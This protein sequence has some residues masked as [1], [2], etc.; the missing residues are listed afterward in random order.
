[1]AWSGGGG[2]F[3][4]APGGAGFAGGPRS[5]AN[6]GG[7][8]PFAGIPPELQAGVDKLLTS[9]PDHGEPRARFS[10]RASAREGRRLT[11]R[12]LLF[13]HW[14]LGALAVL[15]VTV[16]SVAN[17]A[18][19]RLIDAGINHGMG[20]HKD[21]G[22]IV[23]AAVAY[24]IAIVVTAGAQHLQVRV[25]GR[26]AAWVMN[27]LRVKV[28][29]HLQRLG[30]DF[31]TDEK[32]GVIMTRMTSDIEN[33][34][35][36]LQDG[37][38]QFTVQGLTMLVIA[39][40]L[41][42]MN[43][44]LALITVVLIMPALTALSLWFRAASE[45]GY[46]RV[47]DGIA[48]VLA[49]LAESL[50]G[51][52]IVAAHNRQRH[53][54][55]HHRNV[56]G[57]YRDANMYTAQINAV[58]GP[59]TQML[60]YLGSGAILAIGGNMVLHHTLSP[61]DL[62]AFFLYLNR[63]LMPIQLLVQ[64]Y[65]TYQQGQASIIKLRTLF[66][67]APSVPEDPDAEELPP[68]HG[69]IVFEDVTF[70]YDPTNPVI[71]HADLRISAGETVA[72]VGPTGAGKSTLAK[73]VTR[74]YDPGQG[75]VL[76]DGHDLRHVTVGSLRR[77]LGVVPQEPFLFAGTIRDNIA[78]ADPEATDDQVWEAIR[79]VGLVDVVERM[80]AGLDTIVHE[81]G[82]SL[83]SGERQLI[84]L[85]RAFMAR[86][87][88]LVLDEAT[89]NLDL[90]SETKIEAALDVLLE[91]RTAVLIAHRLTTAMKA[92]RIVVV[93]EGQVV[94]IGTH[95]ELV[96]R[97]GRYAAMYATWMSHSDAD[98]ERAH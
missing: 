16:V 74:F 22:A 92:D 88:V 27:D 60:G 5:A 95:D 45:R 90:L 86:P 50:H 96:A 2:V 71:R 83:S 69:E 67:V 20:R 65:N 4:G 51:V 26:L 28:F 18:G 55:V 12:W 77:Q 61:G 30:L 81:R 24:L 63:F 73:L 64:Q 57:E 89:S 43:V 58:Y 8:L 42:S 3:G 87:R 66:E 68:I 15:L 59:G 48:N 13:E 11:L 19:P 39:G 52:R 53:N 9:E 80:P 85:A 76:I 37:L 97:G 25:T 40:L 41:F 72:F 44:R 46:D 14:H 6:P 1:M 54:V 10:Y 62:V 75:R 82:Q 98:P 70:G 33:L 31:Y 56:V 91:A 29:T 84:A 36:L 47:R 34:Q 32:A 94:E 38:A 7:G 93:D 78:F 17:Q 23:A 49:D 21:F 79:A 35:Q